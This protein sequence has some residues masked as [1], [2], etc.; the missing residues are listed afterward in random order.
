MTIIIIIG[1][2]SINN[3]INKTDAV[4]IIAWIASLFSYIGDM[5]LLNTVRRYSNILFTTKLTLA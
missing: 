4:S 1:S 3:M 5:V 2:S